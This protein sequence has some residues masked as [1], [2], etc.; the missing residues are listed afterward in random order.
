MYKMLRGSECM[1]KSSL[2]QLIRL[3]QDMHDHGIHY[4][5]RT[6]YFWVQ[7]QAGFVLSAGCKC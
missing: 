7:S 5:L 1:A 3:I 4:P 6:S 2:K